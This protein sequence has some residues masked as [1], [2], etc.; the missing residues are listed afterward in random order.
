MAQSNDNDDI[1]WLYGK[2]KA[3]GYNI[4]SEAD[5]KSSLANAEDRKW[6]YQKAKGMGLNMGSMADFEGMYAP[7]TTSTPQ[8]QKP[9][10]CCDISNNRKYNACAKHGSCHTAEERQTAHPGTATGDD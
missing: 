3:K 2:L 1:K 4:G 8:K 5:F 10:P 6:Y 7:K 9:A